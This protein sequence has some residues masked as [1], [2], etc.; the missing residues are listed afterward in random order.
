MRLILEKAA[1]IC[2]AAGTGLD[3]IARAQIFYTNFRD[4]APSMEVWAEAFPKDP[5]ACTLIEVHD[6]LPAPNCT[7][8]VDFMAVVD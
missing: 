3:S 2:K 1:A 5:P 6:K 7:M 4:L 8:I